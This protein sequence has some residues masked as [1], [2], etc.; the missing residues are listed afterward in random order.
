MKVNSIE[1]S[2]AGKNKSKD[3]HLPA[4]DV[5]FGSNRILYVLIYSSLAMISSWYDQDWRE[6]DI[7]I[8]ASVWTYRKEW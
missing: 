6:F 2:Q 5:T 4:I 3:V 8:W 1:A 7:S